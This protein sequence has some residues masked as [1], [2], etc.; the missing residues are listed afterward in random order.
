MMNRILTALF[1]LVAL[2]LCIWLGISM[3]A[4][5]IEE[6][7]L[8]RSSAALEER[9]MGWAQVSADGRDVILEGTAPS[10]GARREA[11][12]L[13]RGVWGVR[14]VEDRMNVSEPE[15]PAEEPTTEALESCQDQ[16]DGLLANRS[17]RFDSNSAIIHED[18]FQLLDELAAIASQC[19]EEHIEVAGHADSSGGDALNRRLS[20]A[21]AEAV[22]AALVERGLNPERLSAVGF[23]D[24]RPVA[25]NESAAG[26]ARNRRIEFIVRG[27]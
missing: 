14:V 16:F 19:T 17:I 23:G 2:G 10:E 26:R 5:A 27:N 21:R 4:P 20:R 24:T 15:A 12:T 11:A 3:R 18:N 6:D 1:G 9:S 8:A 25:D 22:V 7:I 13:A